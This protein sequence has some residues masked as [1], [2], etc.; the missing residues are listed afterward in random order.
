LN[1][2][3]EYAEGRIVEKSREGPSSWADGD[4]GLLSVGGMVCMG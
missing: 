1:S 4:C 3:N 2:S